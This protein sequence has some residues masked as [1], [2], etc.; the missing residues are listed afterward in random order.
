MNV[1]QPVRI[2]YIDDS[3]HDR[4]LVRH[5]LEVEHGSFRVTETTA[6]AEFEARLAE[7]EFDLVLSDFNILGYDGLQVLDAVKTTSPRLPV[8]I[9]TGTGSEEIAVQ[10]M[11]CGAADYVIKTPQHI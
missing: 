7:G 4:A 10:A 11:K 2:L 6:R 8:L 3:A 9:V 1:Q 5:A